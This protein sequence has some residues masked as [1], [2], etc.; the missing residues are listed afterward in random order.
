M[1]RKSRGMV[2]DSWALLA[3]LGDEAAGPAV[4]ELIA[5]AHQE[6]LPLLLSVVNAGALWYIIARRFSEAEADHAIADL[7]QLG[8]E[9]VDASWSLVRAASRFKA[10]GRISYADCFAAALAQE[11]KL[12]LLTGDKE[13][14][15]VEDEVQVHWL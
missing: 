13:F 9:F 15:Q 11:K 10:K 1:A 7:R 5:D 8:I 3:Y 6:G 2:L 4:A 14:K 12:E